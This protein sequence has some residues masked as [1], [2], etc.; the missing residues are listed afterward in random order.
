[1]RSFL[2]FL[3][4][5][6]ILEFDDIL[7]AQKA[8]PTEMGPFLTVAIPHYKH[9][10]YL[11]LVLESIFEQQYQDFEILVSNDHSPDDSDEVV[12]GLLADSGRC[13]RYYSQPHNLGYDGNVRFCLAA[14][15]GRYVML[16]GND[17][18][19]AGP[20]VLQELET[21]LHKLD[22]PD[23]AV[24]NYAD[25][26]SGQI[27]QRA[28]ST[29]VVGRGYD[30]AIRFY[31]SFSFVSGLI[32]DRAHA[33]AHET[34]RWDRSVYYQMYIGARLIAED[35]RLGTI[36]LVTV[37]KDVHIDG[38]GVPNYKTKARDAKW[39]FERRSTGVESVLRVTWDGVQPYIP[40][41]DKSKAVRRIIG[42]AYL[43]LHP[44]WILEYRRIANWSYGVG[45]ARGHWPG[46]L[47]TEYDLDLQDRLYLWVLYTGV[48]LIALIMPVDLFNS[49]KFRL[50][51]F[52][53][54]LQ[55][56]RSL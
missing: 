29:H 52:V 26:Q 23:V 4:P 14:A 24:T 56:S 2:Q 35:G 51:H 30:T 43:T 28:L 18:A 34:D 42:Q 13:F 54:I 37:R 8:F 50:A 3:R 6:C 9:V 31:R 7:L 27:V 44:Y 20:T 36:N 16:L 48:T 41:R 53:R 11:A 1:M 19:L 32:Y 17:D 5:G 55:Q 10:R 12:P 25:W 39:S 38:Q 33:L 47:L 22:L 46:K 49:I 21:A 15:Q 45:V 40:A